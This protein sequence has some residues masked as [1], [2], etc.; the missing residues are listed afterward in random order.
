MKKLLGYIRLMRPA[1]V[2]TA[3]AD[4]LAGMALAG[5]FMGTASYLPVLLLCLSTI[6]LYSG[7]IILND[8]FDAEL[9]ARERPERPIP[10]G[11]ISKKA[12]TL[13]GGIFFFIGIFTA[14]LYN[15]ASQYLAAAIM[16]SCLIYDKF[17]K[18]SAIFGPLNM[19]L[20]RG[21]N[22][23]LGMSIIPSAIQQWW[24]LAIVPIIYIASVTMVS[25]A[26]V[27]GG[28]KKMLYFAALLY[29]LV[30]SSILFFGIRQGNLPLTAVFVLG[31]ALMIFIPLL[32]AMKN[33]IGPNIGKAVKAG[34][35]ALI[36]MNA[37]WASAFGMVQIALFIVILLPVSLMLGKAFAVT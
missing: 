12:A 7:G 34:V 11:L 25:R 6:G 10:S 9:D 37:A 14:G 26:E 13:F 28:S 15:P 29:T 24:F 27:H 23:L 20:C 8:V 31:F 5:Y 16:V 3:V 33:P 4:V 19:G 32:R 17:L 22:L 35:I 18:H 2:V 1:N 21:L 36:L 30:I